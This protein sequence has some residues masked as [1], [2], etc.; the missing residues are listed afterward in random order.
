[1][2]VIR[3]GQRRFI[4]KSGNNADYFDELC[5]LGE[6]I[7]Y[8]LG[9]NE[10]AA[11]LYKK[12]EGKAKSYYDFLNLADSVCEKLDNKKWAKKIYMKAEEKR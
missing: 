2:L 4:K 11:K 5:E 9:D 1:M 6:S 12:A 8:K 10:W 7:L 3:I